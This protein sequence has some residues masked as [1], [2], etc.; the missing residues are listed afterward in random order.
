MLVEEPD[1]PG[2]PPGDPFKGGQPVIADAGQVRRQPQDNV[3]QVRPD[4]PELPRVP[5]AAGHE[6]TQLL[7]G[8]LGCHVVLH[9]GD[10]TVDHGDRLDALLPERGT[11]TRLE[12]V[13]PRAGDLVDAALRIVL[14]LLQFRLQSEER[15]GGL[16]VRLPQGLLN[17]VDGRAPRGHLLRALQ[18]DETRGAERDRGG[19]DC[20]GQ[21]RDGHGD[22]V[23]GRQD[24][25]DAAGD[26][27]RV[28]CG[29]QEAAAAAA[30]TA[31]CCGP[32]SSGEE[33]RAS[34]SVAPPA[35][36]AQRA[37][38]GKLGYGRR[39]RTV[40]V[41]V[42]PQHLRLHVQRRRRVL[43][44]LV[45]TEKMFF[46]P[47]HGIGRDIHVGG[48][49]LQ[50]TDHLPVV[51]ADGDLLVPETVQ[52][53]LLSAPTFAMAASTPDTSME[54]RLASGSEPS[55]AFSLPILSIV[56]SMTA[57]N[58]T[59]LAII[60]LKLYLESSTS[61][62]CTTDW[63]PRGIAHHP[64]TDR[65][66]RHFRCLQEAADPLLIT[67]RISSENL[68]HRHPGRHHGSYGSNASTA[69]RRSSP[70][71]I[72]SSTVGRRYGW[73]GTLTD[74][75]RQRP[76]GLSGRPESFQPR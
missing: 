42:V 18:A 61:N 13:D 43:S 34:P 57:L 39:R 58:S 49:V 16:P 32:G 47:P 44:V 9:V 56:P 19:D 29:S 17:G 41:S 8:A 38:G 33:S 7:A 4:V 46:H 67:C 24:P 54:I 59:C 51:P 14:Q 31:A 53:S 70:S 1:T 48:D 55:A 72:A 64:V 68:L 11:H 2:S 6:G 20:G 69:T 5:G 66:P 22:V 26:G 75:C 35:P 36:P 74:R 10:T 73:G 27:V 25:A 76:D 60:R 21:F 71:S 28:A 15:A 3:P 50:V 30:A 45:D 65:R 12:Q 62:G 40:R 52:R 63:S 37:G 23:D